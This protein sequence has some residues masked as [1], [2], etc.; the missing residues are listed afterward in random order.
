MA[1][2]LVLSV[3]LY[4]FSV[5]R[6]EQRKQTGHEWFDRQAEYLTQ[7][8]KFSEQV[9]TVTVLY[10][11]GSISEEDLRNHLYIFRTEISLMKK[12]YEDELKAHP[13]KTGTHT[14]A[15][16]KG[17]EAVYDIYELYS[18]LFNDM[19]SVSSDRDK[20]S[21]TYMTYRALFS[22]DVNM[23]E[24]CKQAIYEDAEEE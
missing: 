20:V 8:D 5:Y 4:G 1:A 6:K 24:V 21:Y 10:T 14:Y 13:V 2:I 3:G 19:E 23:Y 18:E 11:I 15:T 12:A 9:D 16:K 22:K 7:F 17:S